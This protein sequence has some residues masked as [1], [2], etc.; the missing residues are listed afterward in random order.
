MWSINGKSIQSTKAAS[1]NW[2]DNQFFTL[3]YQGK[4]FHGEVLENDLENNRLKVKINHAVYEIKRKGKLDDLIASLGM[5]KPK[6]KRIKEL[7]APMPGRI[8]QLFVE[9]GQEVQVGDSILSLEAMKMENVLKS[10]G[11]GVVKNIQIEVGAVVDKGT[12]LIEFE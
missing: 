11:V 4:S 12:V 9:P 8:L 2:E 6:V 7:Q 1:I 5:D 3:E 10:D